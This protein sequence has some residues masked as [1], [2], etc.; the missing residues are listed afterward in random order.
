MASQQE[1]QASYSEKKSNPI[2]ENV[3]KLVSNNIKT[4]PSVNVKLAQGYREKQALPPIEQGDPGLK[5]VS[6]SVP[7]S[8]V[9][10]VPVLLH[11]SLKIHKH[12]RQDEQESK[13]VDDPPRDYITGRILS[14]YGISCL[15]C[16]QKGL[17]CTFN[18]IGKENEAQCAA[19]RRS[20]A[21]Y[22]VRFKP[23]REEKRRIPFNGPPWV[24][25]N[26]VAGTAEDGTTAPLPRQE[27]ENLLR[28][29]YHGESGYVLGSYVAERDLR[30]YVLPPFNGSDLPLEDRPENYETMNWKDVLPDWRHRSLQPRKD[31]D[32]EAEE[33]K[34]KLALARDRSLMPPNP[35]GEEAE[36]TNNRSVLMMQVVGKSEN[37]DE[38][39]SLLRILRRYEPRERNLVDILG[40]TW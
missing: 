40:E 1:H 11:E 31:K 38:E 17:R 22:C 15:R 23:P 36:E 35:N 12:P 28:E 30:N 33:E 9:E 3:S 2:D 14:E 10:Y 19:C 24:N 7:E 34:K 27:L 37:D 13:A 4:R 20:K 39:V 8:D 29:F 16:T 21:P 6:E 26:F 32:D 25:P 5:G 18:Y